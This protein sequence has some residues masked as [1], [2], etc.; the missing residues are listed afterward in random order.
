[1]AST[2]S[3]VVTPEIALARL[4]LDNAMD[5]Q[6]RRRS[7]IGS[8]RRPTLIKKESGPLTTI[9]ETAIDF[10]ESPTNTAADDKD[11]DD[12]SLANLTGTESK[13]EVV[14]SGIPPEP[15]PN[16]ASQTN[17][18]RSSSDLAA[19]SQQPPPIPPRPQGNAQGQSAE[20]AEKQQVERWAQQQDVREVVANILGQLR[21]A[22][23]GDAVT[24][25]GEQIDRISK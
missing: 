10:T 21:W 12:V 17:D 20:T 19:P 15:A 1:M 22:I 14:L 23:K 2:R 13:D 16:E 3:N 11:M 24:E 4:T 8:D 9:T 5:E 6:G 18:D 25:K 7:T